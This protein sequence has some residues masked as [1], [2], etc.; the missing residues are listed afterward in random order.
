[1]RL[2]YFDDDK[3][4]DVLTENDGEW[5][6]SSG[7]TAAWKS[8]G[9]FGAPLSEV[10]FGRFDPRIRDHRRGINTTHNARLLAH[11]GRP[12]AGDAFVNARLAACPKLVI[13]D[14]HASLRRLHGRWSDRRA[15]RAGG[16]LV[17]LAKRYRPA[18]N[19]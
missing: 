6:I 5:V 18:G 19:G 3:R 12:V 13:P 14:E 10:A 15:R 9:A 11:A 17:D 1:M 16:T 2:G 4:C 8:I 7:G